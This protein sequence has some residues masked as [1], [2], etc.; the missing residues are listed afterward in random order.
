MEADIVRRKTKK[1]NWYYWCSG[2]SNRQKRKHKNS[3]ATPTNLRQNLVLN[4]AR[5]GALNNFRISHFCYWVRSL[6]V[7]KE[8]KKA[9]SGTFGFSYVK[10]T[11]KNAPQSAFIFQ[12]KKTA[13]QTG[14]I[15]TGPN[16]QGKSCVNRCKQN[17][18]WC[19]RHD[20]ARLCLTVPLRTLHQTKVEHRGLCQR[21]TARATPH[22]GCRGSIRTTEEP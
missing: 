11:A 21:R 13:L 19:V 9:I 8:G 12:K 15:H 1:R 22:H 7:Q 17:C 10:S 18:E 14:D 5:W 2:Y 16:S 3:A 20:G 4:V 6:L